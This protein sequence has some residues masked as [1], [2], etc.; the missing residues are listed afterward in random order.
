MCA[1]VPAVVTTANTFECSTET[2]Q[3]LRHAHS[4]LVFLEY[5]LKPWRFCGGTSSHDDTTWVAEDV[6]ETRLLARAELFAARKK[7]ELERHAGEAL[8]WLGGRH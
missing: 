6:L 2:A 4:P 3:P 7:P 8:Q 5:R 1:R